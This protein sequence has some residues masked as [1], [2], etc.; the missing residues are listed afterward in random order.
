MNTDDLTLD[1]QIITKKP[2]KFLIISLAI[3]AIILLFL[4]YF[5]LSLPD[6]SDLK[7]KNPE[8]TSMIELRKK[9]AKKEGK[10]LKIHQK[11]VS[12]ANIPDM[13]KNTVRIS[14][15]AGFYFHKGI[16]YYELKEAIKKN[17]QE[18]KKVRGG[19]TITQQLAK[20]LYLSTKKSYFR[21]I[22][23]F[24]IA[25]KLEKELSKNRIFHLYLNVIEFGRGIFGVAAAGEY[26]FKKPVRR[27]NLVEITR[28]AA[29]IPKPLRVTPL[30]NSRY[31]KWR[32]NLLLDRLY[33]YKY[34]TDE[35]YYSTRE[36]FNDS[37]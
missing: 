25:K 13:L 15:D 3:F 34:I 8:T 9:Q 23:E 33:K 16:D 19:S 14:E 4:A 7:T 36:E 37:K 10:K 1:E 11:W 24:F 26:F 18:G 30:S 29:V 22:R 12:F 2:K 6:V 5:F 20:N 35:E 28:L 31:L 17:L 21:K 32:A 27:L